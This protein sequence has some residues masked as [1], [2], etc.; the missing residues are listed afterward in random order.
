[1]VFHVRGLGSDPD[2]FANNRFGADGS[3]IYTRG[4]ITH[5]QD[6]RGGF[7]VFGKLQGQVADQPLVN[8]EQYT[9]GGL[10][11]VRGYLESET[12]G[13]NAMLGS[14]EFRSPS[15]S[16][17]LGKRVNEWRFYAFAEGGVL[18]LHDPLPEQESQFNLASVGIGSRVRLFDHVSGSLD[19]GFPLVEQ[20]HSG[21]GDVL[22]V[23][24]VGADF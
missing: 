14:I 5:S 11:T 19:V 22:L 8:S 16:A 10:G 2:E 1:M 9:G 23:F 12:L 24:R 20:A 13:D 15:L 7:Q 3:F 17:R 18:T 21:A 4:S 6:L